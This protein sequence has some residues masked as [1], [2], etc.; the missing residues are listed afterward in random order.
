[1]SQLESRPRACRWLAGLMVASL[2]SAVF[3]AAPLAAQDPCEGGKVCVYKESNFRGVPQVIDGENLEKTGLDGDYNHN[4]RS[5]RNKSSKTWCLSNQ[6]E[7][8]DAAPVPLN[9]LEPGEERATLDAAT[10]RTADSL[11]RMGENVSGCPD[12]PVPPSSDRS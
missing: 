6:P 2:P 10:T 9:K 7:G 4:A 11:Y 3:V 12:G 1:M 5:W 8:E